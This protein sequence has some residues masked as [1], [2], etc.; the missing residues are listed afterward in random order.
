MK[1]ITL[2]LLL[3]LTIFTMTACQEKACP[4]GQEKNDK[5]VCV[6]V[7]VDT[8]TITFDVD[9][10]SPVDS[11]QVESGKTVTV[12]T[13][14]TKDGYDFV[15][16]YTTDET[17]SFDFSTVVTGD[18]T[19]KAKW[20]KQLTDAEKI[21][22]DIDYINA[23]LLA[24][25]NRFNAFS[26]GPVHGSNIF[27]VSQSNNITD[28][29]IIVPL[30]KGATDST[31]TITGIFKL[32]DVEKTEAFTVSLTA[33]EDVTIASSRT[34]PFENLTTE[35]EVADG[36]LELFYEDQ[37]TVPYVKLTDMF[38]L[39]EGFIDSETI[40]TSETVDGVL[41]I[42][43][44]FYD[45]EE[46]INYDLILTIDSVENT[47][48]VNDPGFFWAYVYS[49]E[50]NYGR[51]I[52]YKD[53][54]YPGS[55]FDEGD[56]ILYDLDLYNMDVPTYNGEVLIPFHIANQLFVNGYYNVY[57]NVDSLYGIYYVPDV[58]SDEAN[59]ILTSSVS[60]TDL[61]VDL[62][63]FNFNMLAFNFDY[64][65]GLKDIKQVETYY[66]LLFENKNTLLNPNPLSFESGL[67]T[68][69]YKELDDPHTNYQ[70]HSY[71]N[72]SDYEG[73]SLSS[74]GSLGPRYKA[75]YN[76][77]YFAI[78]DAIGEKW[79]ESTDGSWNYTMK[80]N[81][82]FI[83]TKSVVLTLNDFNTADIEV[84]STY[85]KSLAESVLDVQDISTI[86]PD[87]TNGSKFWFYNS[88][89][90]D[91]K[92]LEII[93]KDANSAD[94]TS[95]KQALVAKGATLVKQD[96]VEDEKDNGYYT[97]TVNDI[98]YMIQVGYS[99]DYSAL[100]VSVCDTVPA[101][102]EDEWAVVMDVEGTIDADSAVY[103]ELLLQKVYKI[104][105]TTKNIILDLTFNGGGNIGALYRIMG[106]ITNSPF[107]VSSIDRD[108]GGTS[109]R[110]IDIDSGIPSY[111]AMNWSL[112]TSK[113]T[114]SAAN[115]LVAIFVENNLGDIIGM[116]TGGGA[117]SVTPILLPNGS[118]FTMSSNNIGAVRTG[119]GTELSPYVYNDTEFGF[120]PDFPLAVT[121]I[122]DD[123]T[124]VAIV[125]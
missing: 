82:W 41:T 6:E 66:N 88:S 46:D 9:N 12:P 55:S 62:L 40:F 67:R 53:E 38:A 87:I 76:D 28:K 78:D 25:P 70:F 43:Y 44:D 26:E 21:Q 86:I 93:V 1:K 16:W 48:S 57:Y 51:H 75:T 77:G 20:A 74:L 2:F 68:V 104:K 122:Y 125:E 35:Y 101:A 109:T 114:Y 37:G 30:D 89:T 34:V 108:T 120:T 96:T 105:P 85:D 65:Y 84:S 97:L 33:Q 8:F 54:T 94:S 79:G 11:Q 118:F 32:G 124:L 100:Y 3:A 14:P 107:K 71:Y 72:E 58:G 69:L 106:F 47:I 113:V 98:T 45:E 52:E 29:G 92:I 112:L 103:M 121:N 83:G 24:E 102:Y 5:G 110:Y 56:D 123:A 39:L 81:Y 17:V 61:P 111:A 4:T 95:M 31:G 22:E 15:R 73:W 49:V 7:A 64:M 36:N 42:E 99:S 116:Q 27:W 119:A 18:L 60:G 19:L 117:C 10:G 50:T 63:I 91:E 59:T 23:N 90:Q 115:E 13:A 80:P